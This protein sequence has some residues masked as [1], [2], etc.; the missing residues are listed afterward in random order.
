MPLT[1]WAWLKLADNIK[2]T[3]SVNQM[4][5]RKGPTRQTMQCEAKPS[6]PK[7]KEEKATIVTTG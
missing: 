5:V 1:N 2:H 7:H 3:T 4:V 6:V